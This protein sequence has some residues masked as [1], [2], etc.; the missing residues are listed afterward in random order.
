MSDKSKPQKK[1][2][3]IKLLIISAVCLALMVAALIF[4]MRQDSGEAAEEETTTA[5]PQSQSRLLYDKDPSS[6]ESIAITNDK[7]TYTVKKFADDAWLIED[8]PTTEHD[9]NAMTALLNSSATLTADQVISEDATDL[10]IYGLDKPRAT[11]V[12]TFSDGKARTITVGNDTPQSGLTYA[13][14]DDD[15]KVY[16]IKTSS[17][18]AYMN[19]KFDLLRKRI[20]LVRQAADENDKTDYTKIDRITIERKDLDYPIVLEY[21]VRQDDDNV[22]SG[23]SSTHVMTEPVRLDLNPDKAYDVINNIFGLTASEIVVVAPSDETKAK[24]GFDDPYCTVKWEIAGEPFTVCFGNE[25]KD[26]DGKKAG[27]YGMADGLD[28]I[29][30]FD[31]ADIPWVS[32]DVKS[33]TM[34]MITSNYVYNMDSF[35]ITTPDKHYSFTLN[36]DMANFAA[37]C[38]ET[39]QDMD[40]GLFK[41]YYQYFLRTPAEELYLEETDIAPMVTVKIKAGDKTDLIEYIDIGGRQC[42]IRLNGKMSYQC[43]MTYT[44]RLIEN[45]DRL[46]NGEDMIT[47]W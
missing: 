36:K 28:E 25:Y 46:F 47:T 1:K 13:Q 38:V 39:D 41:N 5:A 42:A 32:C 2:S 16:A 7:S 19:N 45:L 31:L 30:I 14:L 27:Y 12:I 43:R 18:A 10:S 44:N 3:N 24:Y 35:E 9:T 26:A 37:H 33:M 22:I 40:P 8:L 4:L 15:G 6:I 11:A 23:N 17:L 20:Y 21:D 29:F 34:T